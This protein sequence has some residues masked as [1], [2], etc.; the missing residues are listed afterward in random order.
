MRMKL[1]G[2]TV[3][4]ICLAATSTSHATLAVRFI[5][6]GTTLT[7]LDNGAGDTDP[8][9][10][11]IGVA[12]DTIVGT[13]TLS[14]VG[15]GGFPL[16]G[17][18]TDPRL[19]I[20]AVSVTNSGNPGTLR[21]LVSQTDF[22]LSGPVSFSGDLGGAMTTALLSYN[23]FLSQNNALFAETT[24]IGSGLSFTSSAFA[25]TISGTLNVTPFF[26]LTQRIDVTGNAGEL[27][28]FVA[29]DAFLTGSAAAVVPEPE[30]LTLL[31]T[32][33][34]SITAAAAWRRRRQSA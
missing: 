23:V 15:A 2:A 18:P 4:L 11:S 30:S 12:S 3:G 20:N 28:G 33:L 6:G 34:A 16:D 21:I 29:F 13:Y 26:S 19:D 8:T 24:P 14:N 31:G 32:A 7:V 25:D 10:G 5:Q 22:A 9:L 1:L 27:V 17:S